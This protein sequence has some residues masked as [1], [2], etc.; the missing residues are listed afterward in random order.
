MATPKGVNFTITIQTPA[1]DR[2]VDLLQ[3][4]PSKQ[5]TELIQK[6]DAVSSKCD[7]IFS[8]TDTVLADIA[9]LK[10]DHKEI[11]KMLA[12]STKAIL[13]EI[14]TETNAI[15]AEI[16]QLRQNHGT[17]TEAEINIALTS[18]SNRL[19]GVASDPNNPVPATQLSNTSQE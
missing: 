18:V 16:D 6:L 15:A 3:S 9:D 10:S 5:L 2:Y 8:Q 13:A 17:M 7:L 19:K 14:D 4:A 1:L 11:L 12:D